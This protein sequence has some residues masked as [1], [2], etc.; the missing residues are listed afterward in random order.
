MAERDSDPW[1]RTHPLARDVVGSARCD[2]PEPGFEARLLARLRLDHTGVEDAGHQVLHDAG[3]G[4]VDAVE[5]TT[6]ALP[7]PAVGPES[8]ASARGSW[9]VRG[10]SG[11][12]AAYAATATL[13]VAVATVVWIRRGTGEQ[14]G[15]VVPLPVQASVS[16]TATKVSVP[17]EP[18]VR[19]D[20]GIALIDDFEDGNARML[21]HGGR[22]GTWSYV[23]VDLPGPPVP[24]PLAPE[25]LLRSPGNRHVLHARDTGRHDWRGVWATFGPSCYDASAFAGIRFTGK[26]PARIAFELA[27]ADVVEQ[28]YGGA[29]ET[30]CGHRHR[31]TLELTERFEQYE[32]RFDALAQAAETPESAR[33]SLDLRRLL[34]FVF[35]VQSGSESFDFWIDD[36]EWMSKK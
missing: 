20:P 34:A 4:I 22:F 18:A 1:L 3:L 13:A 26:G 24:L 28:E 14:A 15:A 35:V 7:V 27:M 16:D 11:R 23:T 8:K 5:D 2:N 31:S 12:L 33:R 6:T 36:V 17:C 29:C 25:L 30:D 21:A 19:A 9:L 32:V 10:R